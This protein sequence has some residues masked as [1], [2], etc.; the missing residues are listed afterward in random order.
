MHACV[1]MSARGRLLYRV[2]GS[3]TFQQCAGCCCLLYDAH[4]EALACDLRQAGAA[5][6]HSLLQGIGSP[7]VLACVHACV[8][9]CVCVNRYELTAQEYPQRLTACR[10]LRGPKPDGVE[11][12]AAAAPAGATDAN[13]DTDMTAAATATTADDSNQNNAAAGT[14]TAPTE[15]ASADGASGANGVS[16]SGTGGVLTKE[17]QEAAAGVEACWT[18]RI[19]DGDPLEAQV[20]SYGLHTTHTHTSIAEKRIWRPT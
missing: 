3:C 17:E 2:R 4:G 20:G 11:K 1:H 9:V 7:E 13:G 6:R 12:N 15:G 16:R 10:L 14:A 8:C 18:K 5:D 19:A